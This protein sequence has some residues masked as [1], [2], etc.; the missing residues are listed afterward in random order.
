[1]KETTL[2]TSRPYG[3]MAYTHHHARDVH[4][5]HILFVHGFKSD[6]FGSKAAFLQHFCHERGMG[7]TAL[8][9]MAHGESDGDMMNFTLGQALDDVTFC[10]HQIID[11]P[12]ILVG[13]S[14]GGWLGLRAAEQQPNRIR[15]L[16]GIAPAPDFTAE[17]SQ[18][19]NEEQLVEMANNGYIAQDSGYEEPYIFTRALIED[20]YQHLM[21]HRDITYDGP[22]TILQG[23]Q[24]TAVDWKKAQRISACLPKPATIH[25]IEDGDHSLS[26]PS[27]LKC[28]QDAI[29]SLI[30]PQGA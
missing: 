6:R 9:C 24:D 2:Y 11:R 27:D 22:V 17:I 7:Y 19:M 16:I 30:T 20:G 8:D 14:M 25:F 29:L 15:A 4:A 13:S 5:A 3:R 18:A 1:M 26:R 12:V 28:L 21:L 23:Q 10:L